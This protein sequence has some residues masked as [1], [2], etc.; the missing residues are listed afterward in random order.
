MVGKE[1]RR[2]GPWAMTVAAAPR[3]G[4]LTTP[5]EDRTR[6][7]VPNGMNRGWRIVWLVGGGLACLEWAA[8]I[9]LLSALVCPT[10]TLTTVTLTSTAVAPPPHPTERISVGAHYGDCAGV[11]LAVILQPEPCGWEEPRRRIKVV[12]R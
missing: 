1:A 5:R 2:P 12:S 6:R 3:C 11:T 10:C 7:P 8:K 9:S 4:F